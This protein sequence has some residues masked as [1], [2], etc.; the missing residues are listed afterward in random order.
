[1]KIGWIGKEP[2]VNSS[3]LAFTM[4]LVVEDPVHAHDPRASTLHLFGFDH[5]DLR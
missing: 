5:T 3:R 4:W 2:V 1:M